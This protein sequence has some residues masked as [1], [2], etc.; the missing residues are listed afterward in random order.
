[1]QQSQPLPHI[2]QRQ[3]V[4]ALA[5]AGRGRVG[6][7]DHHGAAALEGGN[8]QLRAAGAGLHAVLDGVLHQ[9]LQQ[10]RRQLGL[11]GVGVQAP[12][13]LQAL[14]ETDLLDGQVALG[15][16]D[17]L[18]Q[19]DGFGRVGQ[20]VAEQF[21]EVFQHGFG[22]GRL[23]AHQRN[24]AVE[25]VEQ[26][27]GA[28]A[29]L[30]LGQARR[31]GRRRARLGAPE[32][33]RQQHGR[34]QR[35]RRRA[36]LPG[37]P[38]QQPHHRQQAATVQARARAQ[39]HPGRP[40]LP[41]PEP[42]QPRLEGAGHDQPG[43]RGRQHAA[44]QQGKA[45]QPLKGVVGAEHG[46][47]AHHRFGEQH[48]PQ[49][50]ADLAGVEH[51][52]ARAA[53][54]PRGLLVAGD[55]AAQQR[56][57]PEIVRIWRRLHGVAGAGSRADEKRVPRH[58]DKITEMPSIAPVAPLW[59]RREDNQG[60]RRPVLAQNSASGAPNPQPA[61]KPDVNQFDKKSQAWSALFSEPMSDLVKRYTSSVF[62]D[63]RLWQADIAG[64]LAHAEMLAA[65]KIIPA[66]DY[67]DIQKGMA[68]ITAEIE[69]GAFEWKL[70]LEDV[71]FNIEARL[72][73]LVGDAGKRLHTGRSRNDQ[74]ATDVR[75]WL[76][77]E[78]DLIGGLLTDLQKAL[79]DIAE[80]NA[81]VIL[82]GF[83]HLQVAQPVSFGHHMLA[84]VEMFSRDAE[85]MQEIRKRVNRLPLGA[86]ALAGTSYPLDRE[87]AAKTLGMV[88][89]MGKPQVCQN[90][91][92]AVS[93]RDF[94]IEFTAAAS[95]AMVHISRMSEE[96]ILWMSQNFGFIHIPDRFTTG[97]SIMPQKKNPDVPELA[98]GKTGR[99]VGHL[100]GLITLMKGQPLAY[101]KDNQEDK[102]PLFDTVD[103]LKDTLRIFAEMPWK[104]AALRGYATATD[105]A[106]YL[107]KKGLPFRDAHET[108]AHAV[109]AAT[110]H[111]VDL[112]ELPL[113]VLQEFNPSI[114]KD[115][116]DCLS[117]RGS[118]NA[119]N[120]L[121]GTA[122]AQV[123][124]QIARHRA[125]LG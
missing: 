31:R 112:S 51:A 63:K 20:R 110:T 59:R 32:Q 46:G 108:V 67:A 121:G 33:A 55:D 25:G 79:V 94:A 109:K 72:T 3:A 15:Q 119:R 122:P 1:M 91:L 80:K 48:G 73:Q 10:Q 12:L 2:G 64:S 37:R 96:L 77:G 54:A 115:V 117:L 35:T 65:Q 50:H 45:Q 120:I 16:Q 29:R 18:P 74:V 71:H 27:M 57:F 99:V 69:S 34:Q 17:F 124:A 38:Q 6:D 44:G 39:Q 60:R 76:R 90:S 84:Y 92:D 9:R 4:A 98:R 87:R 7:L 100:M 23:G 88:D 106:D 22:L 105:L 118:L 123:K 97:S 104:K 85:R 75:L 58:M 24:G 56:G 93:D 70:D 43:Q 81:E 83:T 14:A 53:A 66:A 61:R 41:V 52:G 78:I 125:R 114:E 111:A 40:L 113:A 95:L 89:E 47:H 82:P 36:G 49:H 28:Y 103:T 13:H 102:E 30:Q 11:V 86:A 21:A 5:G 116:Y 26:E 19:R 8:P 68:Q 42:V 62:F 107:V 101:N